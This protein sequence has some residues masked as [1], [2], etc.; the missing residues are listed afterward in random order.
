MRSGAVELALELEEHGYGWIDAKAKAATAA[1]GAT[2]TSAIDTW[3]RASAARRPPA[4]RALPWPT[5]RAGPTR[6]PVSPTSAGRR[7]PSGGLAPLARLR[8]AHYLRARSAAH[9]AA[10]LATLRAALDNGHWLV[11]VDRRFAPPLSAI[12]TL[13]AGVTVGERCRMR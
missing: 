12:N 1:A 8:A 4:R 7:N 5:R 10:T 9:P 3:V 6:S 13:P 11:F 2:A